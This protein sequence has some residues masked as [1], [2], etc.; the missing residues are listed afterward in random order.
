MECHFNRVDLRLV[1][2]VSSEVKFPDHLVFLTH[3]F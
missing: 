2:L 1:M 3:K